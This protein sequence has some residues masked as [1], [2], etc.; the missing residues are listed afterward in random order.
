MYFGLTLSYA[1]KVYWKRIENQPVFRQKEND[2]FYIVLVNYA[3]DF[4]Q[5]VSEIGE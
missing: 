5:N 3:N 2:L 1:R 4:E